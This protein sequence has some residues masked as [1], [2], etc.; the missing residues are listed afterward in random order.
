MLSSFVVGNNSFHEASSLTLSS[1]F[2]MDYWRDL[3]NL[4]ITRFEV[5]SFKQC[6]NLVLKGCDSS[7]SW[8][9]L[10]K[11]V[12]FTVG[13]NAFVSVNSIVLKSLWL[14]LWEEETFLLWTV[15]IS[16]MTRQITIPSL[17]LHPILSLRQVFLWFVK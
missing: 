14:L 2:W 9:D 1:Y 17:V 4:I 15:S 5:N 7:F 10:P 12:S 16:Q 13:K 6:R 8:F 3:P 11:L